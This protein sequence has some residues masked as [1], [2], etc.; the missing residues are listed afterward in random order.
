MATEKWSEILANRPAGPLAGTEGMVLTQGGQ[1][2]GLILDTLKAWLQVKNNLT[3]TTDPTVNDDSGAG[4]EPKSKWLNTSSG[5]WFICSSAAA[6]AA[7]WEPMTLSADE[8]GSAALV[9]TGTGAADVPLNSDLGSAAYEQFNRMPFTNLIG[10][11]GRF[12]D[13]SALSEGHF[14][15]DLGASPFAKTSY[16]ESYNGSTFASAGQFIHNNTDF[17]GTAGNMTQTLVDLM[18]ALGRSGNTARFGVEFHVLEVLAGSGTAA[19]VA[20]TAGDLYLMTL[21]G[22]KAFFG[23]DN[24]TTFCGW[25]RAVDGEAGLFGPTTDSI[26]FVNQAET[27]DKPYLLQPSDGWVFVESFRQV[28]QGYD[29]SFPRFY[30]EQSTTKVQIALAGSFPGWVRTG[31]HSAPMPSAGMIA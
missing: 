20:G 29:T 2:V 25:V 7:A 5:E 18:A 19:P 22:N 16:F 31:G 4:Y 13:M 24:F 14:A 17:G 1:S 10:Y 9:N 23:A 26:N 28:A 12:A 3:A 8:L 30:G 6:G 15:R 11:S 27:S 21:N